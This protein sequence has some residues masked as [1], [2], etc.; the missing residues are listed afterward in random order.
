MF[1]LI[2]NYHIPTVLL[3]PKGDIKCTVETHVPIT[4]SGSC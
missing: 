2:Q 3:D 4:K 1:V